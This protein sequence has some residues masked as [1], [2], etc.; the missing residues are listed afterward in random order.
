MR[1]LIFILLIVVP[2][3]CFAQ[4][5]TKLWESNLEAKRSF[6]IYQ[7]IENWDGQL[8]AIGEGNFTESK[9]RDGA[10]VLLDPE[11]GKSNARRVGHLGDD[12]LMDGIRT[13]DGGFI[14]TGIRTKKGKKEFQFVKVDE[15]LGVIW[16]ESFGEADADDRLFIEA[17]PENLFYLVYYDDS[18]IQILLTDGLKKEFE[19]RIGDNVVEELIDFE[20]NERGILTLLASTRKS[21]NTKKGDY[22]IAQLNP[23]G[24]LLWQKSYGNKEFEEPKGLANIH[25]GNVVAFGVRWTNGLDEDVFWDLI[26]SEGNIF[27]SGIY[28][29]NDTD[30]PLDIVEGPINQLNIVGG[31][32]S[33]SLGSRV[34]Y[35]FICMTDYEGWTADPYLLQ[36]DN[37]ARFAGPI[38]KSFDDN[39][40]LVLQSESA[41]KDPVTILKLEPDGQPTVDSSQSSLTMEF[42]KQVDLSG[43]Q[44]L[45]QGERGYAL[46]EIHNKDLKPSG[47]AVIEIIP[48]DR[49]PNLEF[50]KSIMIPNLEGGE[51]IKLPVPFTVK[52]GKIKPSENVKLQI[53]K[54]GTVIEET[55]ISIAYFIRPKAQE[56]EP[57]PQAQE[58]KV[59]VDL[60]WRLPDP[61]ENDLKNLET[62]Q[63]FQEIELRATTTVELSADDFQLYCNGTLIEKGSELKSRQLNDSN[64]YAYT[65][66]IPLMEG[67]N[68]IELSV[69][70]KDQE[71]TAFPLNFNYKIEKTRPP[72]PCYR[73]FLF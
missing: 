62:L 31:T 25:G 5:L 59:V 40:V 7:I 53:T 56:P 44:Q 54:G 14:L 2:N 51:R 50:W 36:E 70:V 30:L 39:F 24:E 57:T 33:L 8:I 15:H 23:D 26:N 69:K 45:Q 64:I 55:T 32:Q 3:F 20:V 63:A 6:H 52:K 13:L 58:E 27:K 37:L 29:G 48:I 21:K 42:I 65:N 71:F 46:I 19:K 22:W 73:P 35:S 61:L 9:D 28:K 43:D 41:S 72:Y 49:D 16:E 38:S 60:A 47:A 1:Y 68:K 67:P 10:V 18:A 66:R 34:P 4:P 11:T 12:F 17:G